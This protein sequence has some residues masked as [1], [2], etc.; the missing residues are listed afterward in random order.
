MVQPQRRLRT[1]QPARPCRARPGP[2]ARAGPDD[3]LRRYWPRMLRYRSPLL[4]AW[5]ALIALAVMAMPV[6]GAHLHLC[7]D[8]GEPPATFHPI[9]DGEAH[10]APAASGTHNDK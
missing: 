4:R 6:S 2:R 3:T 7:F 10:D 8:G 5:I 9:E 1:A